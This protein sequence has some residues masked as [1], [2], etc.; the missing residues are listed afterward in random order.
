MAVVIR[1]QGLRVTAG[2]EDIRR[3]FTGLRIPDGG[4]HIIGGEQEEAFIIFAS[5][6]DARR[7]MT[8]SGGLIKNAPVTLLLSSREEMQSMLERSTR[9]LDQKRHLEESARYA[10]RSQDPEVGRR[11]V[12]RS[13]YSPLSHHQ[14]DANTDVFLFLRG[15]PYTV[16]EKEVYDFFGGLPIDEIILL[17]KK[18]GANNGSGY[19]KFATSEAAVEGLK[20]DREYL[21]SRY[22]E[23][24]KSNITEWCLATDKGP[25][26]VFKVD[27]IERGRS[28]ACTPRNPQ[29][30][31][32]SRSPIAHRHVASSNEEYCILLENLSFAVEKQ[33]IKQLFHS[34]KLGDDQIM[35]LLN[36]NGSRTRSAFVLFKNQR[37]YSNA[38]TSEQAR[39]LNRRVFSHPVSKENM[40]SL[41]EAQ[42]AVIPLPR[43]LE[44]F[45]EK[46]TSHSS[47]PYESEK[48]CVFVQNLPFDVRKVEI[49]DFFHGFNITED[50]VYMLRDHEGAGIGKA[51]VL[52]G[53]EAEATRARSL[54][55]RRFL[56]S[57]VILKV[58]SHSQMQQLRADPPEL[59]EQLPRV[60]RYL[61]R[62]S[63]AA[64]G[65]TSYPDHGGAR[66]GNML[67]SIVH[68]H[69]QRGCDYEPRAVD[70]RSLQ[71]RGNGF[72]GSVDSPVQRL[73]GPTCVKLLNLPFKI[74]TEEI[75]DF[76]YGYCIVPGSVSLLLNQDGNPQGS[77]TVVFE[78]RQEALV[79]IRELNGRSIGP[80]KIE[81]L[82]L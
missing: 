69:T 74:R 82:L 29:R 51:L 14:R 39:L 32:R 63:R 45:Q 28:P 37:D 64:S 67:T 57:E 24:L 41:L 58:I 60:D 50:K 47:D 36:S 1:L 31:S 55:G 40:L 30:H 38:L 68:S 66:D 46:S 13:G 78:S 12:R 5:D 16:T 17:K 65:E 71:N 2:A 4:V 44:R 10:G 23:L 3:F 49:M 59:R 25:A 76:C 7:A 73:D 18:T 19:V 62:S 70:L 9:E 21:G 42:S 61:G 34:A 80:R 22:I 20:K 77:A 27:N 53:S 54:E 35:F 79:A 33:D 26:V 6:E 11:A 81:L 56:G 8:R 52:F 43:N 75:Y 48:V 15:L 72:R